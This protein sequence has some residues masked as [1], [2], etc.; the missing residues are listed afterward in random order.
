MSIKTINLTI[1]LPMIFHFHQPVDNK[2]FV[3][4]DC[5]KKAY[6]PLIENLY[7]FPDI[8]FTLHFSGNLLEWFL[9]NK[10]D[11]ISKLKNMAKRNQLEIIGGGYYEPIFAIIPDRDKIAQ[12]KKL[13]ALIKKEFGLQV[14]GA[15]LSERVWEPNYP[16]FL[17]EVGLNYIIVDDNHFRST[18]ITEKDTLYSYNTEDNAKTIRVFPINEPLR[19]YAPWKPTN[20]TIDY[21]RKMADI[22][23]DRIALFI[24]DAEKMGVWQKT[25]ELCYI[26]G[27]LKGD[28]K[29]PFIPTLLKKIT[30]NKWIKPITLS[31]YMERYPAKGLVYLPTSSYDKMEEWVLP[32]EIRINFKKIKDKIKNNPDL[33]NTYQFFKGGFWRHFLV[34]YPESNNMHK[35]MLYIREKV[36]K[37]EEQ[38]KRINN[39]KIA[40]KIKRKIKNAWDEIYKAQCND[41]YWHGLFGGVYLQFLRF[42]VYTHLINAEKIIDEI[43]ILIFSK[44]ESYISISSFD[45]NKDSKT[46]ILIES[47][48]LNLYINPHDGGTIFELDYKPGSYNLLNTITR[49]YEAYHDRISIKTNKVMVDRYKK[50]MFRIRFL[51]K[52]TALKQIVSDTYNEYGDF[53]NADFNIVKHEKKAGKAIIKMDYKGYIKDTLSKQS[54]SCL[55]N[56]EI[57]QKNNIITLTINGSFKGNAKKENA[58]LNRIINN[59]NIGIDIPFYFNGD[60]KNA[61][62]ISNQHAFKTEEEKSLNLPFRYEGSHFKAVDTDN[63]LQFEINTLNT[64][65]FI[66]YPIIT[67]TNTDQGYMEMYQG[68]A[69]TVISKIKNEFNITIEL[70]I[71]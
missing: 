11:F 42:S 43:N 40:L 69:I 1:N 41:C 4:V 12:I 44:K 61:R 49:W 23:G 48:I 71:Y 52:K 39:K 65:R 62:W 32:S 24:S 38:L 58:V 57:Q 54:I 70:K 37:A 5:Y 10:P 18:G 29:K 25:H 14:K 47:N 16:G 15:W 66:K 6:G 9:N 8:K 21:L 46:N 31:E 34:K 13:S 55:I 26:K 28:K 64:C 17:N 22:N 27:H 51:H 7:K 30:E 63:K 2:D 19:Y 35:K 45:F 53:V 20:F 68:I 56:K 50:S 60:I 59:L 3:Y 33:S 36:I 67:Y